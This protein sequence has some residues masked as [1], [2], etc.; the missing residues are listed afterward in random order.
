MFQIIGIILLV[1]F[2]ASNFKRMLG[3]VLQIIVTILGFYLHPIIGIFLAICYISSWFHK[4][5][6]PKQNNDNRQRQQNSYQ[7]RTNN[8]Q[9]RKEYQERPNQQTESNTFSYFKGCTTKE[10]LKKRHRE[11]CKK[12]HPDKGGNPETFKKMQAEYESIKVKF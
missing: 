11:L 5:E 1:I 8:Q 3:L 10:Q 6:Q 9:Q 7:Q 12:Y 4:E 2:V